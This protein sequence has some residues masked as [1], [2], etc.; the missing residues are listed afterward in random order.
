[1]KKVITFL[2]SF[3]LLIG[4]LAGCGNGS[5]AGTETE[6]DQDFK[7]GFIFLHDENSTYDKNFIDAA[8]AASA[9]FEKLMIAFLEAL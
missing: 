6:Q 5:S 1:M 4:C 2:L 3:S 8:N 9:R 7:V